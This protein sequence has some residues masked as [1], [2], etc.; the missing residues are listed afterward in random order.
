MKRSV[1]I[2]SA[3]LS[4]ALFSLPAFVGAELPQDVAEAVQAAAESYS[5]FDDDV[6]ES[7]RPV[8]QRSSSTQ[9]ETPAKTYTPEERAKFWNDVKDV[10]PQAGDNVSKYMSP[11]EIADVNRA[12]RK[13]TGSDAGESAAQ[14]AQSSETVSSAARGE[15]VRSAESGLPRSDTFGAE[16]TMGGAASES[17]GSTRSAS[18]SIGTRSGS[19][20][21]E[22]TMGRQSDS[23]N[24]QR[25]LGG[26]T[27]ARTPAAAG[28]SFSA[29]RTLGGETAARTPSTPA[30]ESFNAARTM[31]AEPGAAG[32]P[33]AGSKVIPAVEPK[34]F[35]GSQEAP[36]ARYSGGMQEK[37]TS[38]SDMRTRQL[39]ES[40]QSG[41]DA[42]TRAA[43]DNFQRGAATE[44]DMMTLRRNNQQ[45]Q[46]DAHRGSIPKDSYV[47]LQNDF[48]TWMD[49][50]VQQ[51]ASEAGL[52]GRKQVA[53]GAPKPGTDFDGLAAPKEGQT[54][55]PEQYRQARENLNE[56]V[57]KQLKDAGLKPLDNPSRQLETD[58]MPDAEKVSKETFRAVEK[59]V[60]TDGGV[61]YGDQNAAKVER[62]IR[63]GELPTAKDNVSHVQEQVRQ[64]RS[65][66]AEATHLI[67]EGRRLMDANPEGS[68]G[69]K[70]GQ[71]LIERGQL[72]AE[73]GIKYEQRMEGGDGRIGAQTAKDGTPFRPDTPSQRQLEQIAGKRPIETRLSTESERKLAVEMAQEN[74]RANMPEGTPPDQARKLF[75]QAGQRAEGQIARLDDIYRRNFQEAEQA[76]LKQGKDPATARLI[77]EQAGERARGQAQ[78][79]TVAATAEN[80]IGQRQHAVADKLVDANRPELAAEVGRNMTP[81]ERG[82]LLDNTYNRAYEEARRGLGNLSPEEAHRIA[83]QAA[84]KEQ[85]KLAA[86]M[87]KNPIADRFNPAENRWEQNSQLGGNK[88]ESGGPAAKPGMI[89]SGRNMLEG[90]VEGAA[91]VDTAIADGLGRRLGVEAPGAN[92]S[93][94]RRGL[95]SAGAAGAIDKGFKGVLVYEGVKDSAQIA[96]DIAYAMD[97]TTSDA[98]A[99]E[100]FDH[101]H[102]TAGRMAVGGSVGA[103]LAVTPGGNLVGAGLAGYAGGRWVM[104]NTESGRAF[105]DLKVDGVDAVQRAGEGLSDAWNGLAG[106]ETVAMAEEGRTKD[107]QLA[108]LRALQRG[109]IELK[110]GQTVQDLMD[111]IKRNGPNVTGSS[112]VEKSARDDLAQIDKLIE[113]TRPG[114]GESEILNRI[115][116]DIQHGTPEE[117]AAARAA[118]NDIQRLT[119]QGDRT[120][121]GPIVNP[122]D[123]AHQQD[124][125]ARINRL[126]NNTDDPAERARLR[127]IRAGLESDDR[128]IRGSAWIDMNDAQRRFDEMHQQPDEAGEG[129]D[130]RVVSVPRDRFDGMSTRDALQAAIDESR[131]VADLS[132]KS[133]QDD[134][135]PQ[136]PGPVWSAEQLRNDNYN[137]ANLESRTLDDIRNLR[138]QMQGRGL[139]P[140]DRAALGQQLQ[141]KLN[142]LRDIQGRIAD[143]NQLLIDQGASPDGPTGG[144]LQQAREGIEGQ[145]SQLKGDIASLMGQL[146][147]NHDPSTTSNLLEQLNQARAN[148]AN[149]QHN[150]D[151]VNNRINGVQPPA[152]PDGP[153]PWTTEGLENDIWNMQNLAG[154]VQDK[155][156]DLENQLANSNDSSERR[157]ILDELDRQR[158]ELDALNNRID[159]DEDAIARN[160]AA[161]L[162]GDG[163]GGAGDDE[164]LVSLPGGPDDEPAD[165]SG[166]DDDPADDAGDDEPP[167]D[168]VDLSDIDDDLFDDLGD[169]DDPGDDI[170]FGA[171]VLD[172]RRTA[173]QAGQVDDKAQALINAG[174]LVLSGSRGATDDGSAFGDGLTDGLQQGIGSSGGSGGSSGGSDEASEGGEKPEE[175]MIQQPPQDQPP[176]KKPAKKKKKKKHHGGG[177]IYDGGGGGGGCA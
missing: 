37:P 153:S 11:E 10:S 69:F 155:I 26:E 135:V 99:N 84:I 105:E 56:I 162:F 158:R 160:T 80:R 79:G 126:I 15:S 145:V 175:T 146:G 6:Y 167:M 174:G 74:A 90:A 132:D 107:I 114:S 97:P 9:A 2:V 13:M 41:M 67:D 75:E 151:S 119:D 123:D 163:G 170:D 165:R 103:A 117:K 88:P 120:W 122:F 24:A 127:D 154:K 81:A 157:R 73:Q 27:G 25:T 109:D 44:T 171:T 40:A 47:K 148:L 64:A 17:A 77:A 115:A 106:Y 118:L 85:N 96:G 147:R 112:L 57:N 20:S 121:A 150:L 137:M 176:K 45:V 23:F 152:P 31:G 21:S 34:P 140:A 59:M 66:V 111:D 138:E 133:P 168:D 141:D 149:A 100:A 95:N 1:F 134:V 12:Y 63:D 110:P 4:T 144:Q 156:A 143:N 18:E 61:M 29:E 89:Q 91:G 58:I 28:E 53:S 72:R 136:E 101:A 16:R 86:E 130:T 128:D 22:Q 50:N 104:E 142:E 7:D 129:D 48:N 124:D 8:E 76:A 172:D 43:Y 60:N 177:P 51:A 93:A 92:S 54:A 39:T 36:G 169:D 113:G 19:F 62:M 32:T 14:S 108:H 30:G 83:D 87:R 68:E 70:K 3:A 78:L 71:E 55:T 52:V 159:E 46:M 33:P 102:Q 98:D 42:Q 116:I 38:V 131:G 161:T 65:H 166:D 164:P 35:Y 82:R 125:L 5:T 139:S 94:L 173:S 49:K